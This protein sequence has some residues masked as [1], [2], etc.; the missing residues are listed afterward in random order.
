MRARYYD[1][2]TTAAHDAEVALVRGAEG[3][4][5]SVRLVDGDLDFPLGA[6]RLGERVG[7]THRLIG[8]PDRASLE[9]LD[10]PTFD[11]ALAREGASTPEAPLRQLEARW[12]YG[13]V[14]L[15]AVVGLTWG[16]LRFGAPALAAVALRFIPPSAD[17][18]VASD[19]LALLDRIAFKPSQL[20]AA[21]RTELRARFAEIADA[22]APG[23]GYRLEFRGGGS[24]GANA[25]A[26]PAGVVVLTDEL[27]ALAAN[28]DELRGVLA[29]EVGHL[30][31]RH[32]MRH[33]IAS[34]TTALLIGAVLGDVSGSSGLIA[35]VPTVLVDSAYSRDLERE[36]DDFAFRYLAAHDVDPAA[37][38][39]LLE[40]LAEQ[41]GGES[42]GLLAS[43]P[44]FQERVRAAAASRH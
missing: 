18:L 37:L 8:L 25:L 22:A 29:H 9:I 27:V 7:A 41:H 3:V 10:D 42:G 17:A 40:R 20:D 6:V 11:A 32:A 35:S 34:S 21:R 19:G 23:G 16:G 44:S 2:R 43:H 26:L 12:R 39:R 36:A 4:R 13:I 38:G 24:I 15:V 14:A 1:G 5:V 30:A 31:R 28:D 33:L